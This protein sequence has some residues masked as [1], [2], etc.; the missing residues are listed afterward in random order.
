MAVAFQTEVLAAVRRNR[1]LL[2]R[3][4]DRWTL[5]IVSNFFGNLEVCLEVV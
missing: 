4:A 5:G 2:A 1:P 3:L